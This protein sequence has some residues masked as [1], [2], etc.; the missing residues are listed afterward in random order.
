MT[1]QRVTLTV[2]LLLEPLLKRYP[3][4]G[5]APCVALQKRTSSPHRQTTCISSCRP[6][7]KGPTCIFFREMLILSVWALSV[8]SEVMLPGMI[9]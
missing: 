5:Y 8:S 9:L 7:G 6:L 3:L 1:R 2:E 4:I